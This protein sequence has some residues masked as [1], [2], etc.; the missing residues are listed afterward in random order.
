MDR[1]MSL[2]SEFLQRILQVISCFLWKGRV[3]DDLRRVEDMAV[4]AQSAVVDTNHDA[5]PFDF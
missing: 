4:T 1:A 2:P 3:A 5:L